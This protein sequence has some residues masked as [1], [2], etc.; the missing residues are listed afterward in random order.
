M[1]RWALGLICC[2][3]QLKVDVPLVNVVATITDDKGRYVANLSPDDLIVEEDGEPQT[4]AHFTQ[5]RDLPVSVGIVLD[6]SASMEPKISTA[7]SAVEHFIRTI[8]AGD[9]VFL[10]T[11]STLPVLQ[12]DFTSDREKLARVLRGRGVHGSTA[13]YDALVAGLRKIK[14]GKHQKKA[15][16]LISDGDDTLSSNSFESAAL[17]VRE[18]ELLVYALGI[19]PSG[20]GT[21]SEP[22]TAKGSAESVDMDVLH[23]FADSSGGKAWLVSGQK[24]SRTNQIQEALD[25]IA[26]EL[27]NQYSIGYYPSHPLNDGK[28]HRIRIR[29]K[30]PQYQVRARKEYYGGDGECP[31]LPFFSPCEPLFAPQQLKDR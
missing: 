6:T 2:L 16:L 20:L 31:Y 13:L 7:T 17:A 8:H 5:A 23:A 28:W 30:N 9:D 18:S 1:R 22:P 19:A 12:Q 26:S 15:I 29:L 21:I 3:L 27:R 25:E 11:F 4:I 10:M 14:S 24:D